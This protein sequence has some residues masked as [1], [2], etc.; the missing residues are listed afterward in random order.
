MLKIA[1]ANTPGQ[2]VRATVRVTAGCYDADV[3]FLVDAGS[4]VSILPKSVMCDNF[5]S[6][7]L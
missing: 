6:A 5:P 2:R 1:T 7:N 3:N 4:S